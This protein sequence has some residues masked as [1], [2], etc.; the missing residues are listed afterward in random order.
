MI[1]YNNSA[2]TPNIHV[3][4]LNFLKT[5]PVRLGLH[6]ILLFRR[7]IFVPLECK[8]NSCSVITSIC[9][10][11]SYCWWFCLVFSLFRFVLGL[12]FER[13]YFLWWI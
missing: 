6:T 5:S 12:L 1:T 2:I 13:C 10:A 4:V 3:R 9:Y 7:S 11:N 8:R